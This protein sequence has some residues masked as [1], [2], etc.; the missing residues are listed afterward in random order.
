LR[1]NALKSRHEPLATKGLNKPLST[2]VRTV[3][4]RLPFG[5]PFAAIGI[6]SSSARA[7]IYLHGLSSHQRPDR[8]PEF[9]LDQPRRHRISKVA[10]HN[11][12][13][14]AAKRSPM[15]QVATP[16]VFPSWRKPSA[17]AGRSELCAASAREGHSTTPSEAEPRRPPQRSRRAKVPQLRLCETSAY[18]A[19]HLRQ[20][21]RCARS[22]LS[23]SSTTQFHSQDGAVI[24]SLSR[25]IEFALPSFPVRL[26]HLPPV[27]L[28]NDGRKKCR[29]VRRF[30]A[31]EFLH[32]DLEVLWQK[33]ANK[34]VL[35]NKPDPAFPKAGY[36]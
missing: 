13:K 24:D 10:S 36:R 12:T 28:S 20:C 34:D 32:V 17:T 4:F 16:I 8:R 21:S 11:R 2:L 6:G 25:A 18:A 5:V 31:A 35:P 23:K 19:A 3:A 33:L 7:E 27:R 1:T 22:C 29:D 30:L 14:D 26:I 15:P 9:E